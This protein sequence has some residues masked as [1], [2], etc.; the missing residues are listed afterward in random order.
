[1]I[2]FENIVKSFDEPIELLVGIHSDEECIG[3]KRE[4]ILNEDIRCETVEHCKY[5]DKII[6]NAP[7]VVS[8]ELI[9]EYNIDCVIIGEE[10]RGNNDYKWYGVAMDMGIEK[11]IPRY[12]KLSSS[13]IINKVKIQ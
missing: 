8:K 9:A 1:M 13:D 2:L 6:K 4:P 7:L 12:D 10:Y 11:Y 5:V 3:Y